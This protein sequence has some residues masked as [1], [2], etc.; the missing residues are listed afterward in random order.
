MLVIRQ[1]LLYRRCGL[2]SGVMRNFSKFHAIS[3]LVTGAHKI[4]LALVIKEVASSQG[5]GSLSLRNLKIGWEFSPFTS[6]F[7][8]IGNFGSNPFPGRTYFKVFKISTPLP[9]SCKRIETPCC[10]HTKIC[11]LSWVHI[12]YLEYQYGVNQGIQFTVASVNE[13]P[14]TRLSVFICQILRNLFL[15][16]RLI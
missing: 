3:F 10:F 12:N 11:M 9:F 13:S 8:K 1:C 5:I 14:G 4:L 6:S 2:P 15:P 16:D 7:S